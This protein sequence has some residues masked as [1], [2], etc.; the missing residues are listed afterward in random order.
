MHRAF[1]EDAAMT[2]SRGRHVRE[3]VASGAGS[4]R[5]A[6]LVTVDQLISS[7]SN[8]LV[9]IWVAHALPPAGFGRFSLV[10]LI[11]VFTQT[12]VVRSLVSATVVVHP[13]DADERPRWVLGT[14]VLLSVVAGVLCVGAGGILWWA[15]SALGSPVLLVGLLMP[16]LAVQDVGRYLGIAQSRPGKAVVLD[17]IW[18]VL[19]AVGIVAVEVVHKPTLLWIVTA[20]ATT[21]AVAGLW[22]FVQHGFPR[23]RELS[24]DWLRHRWHFSW[25]SLVA[26]SSTAIVAL[27]GSSLMAV[28]SGPVAVAALRAALLLERP[29]TTVQT[30]VATSAATDIARERPDNA[31]LLAYQRRTMILSVA[32]AALNMLVVLMIPDSVGR[33]V[34]GQVWHVV[35]PLLLVVGFHVGAFAAQSGVRAALIGR[36]RIESV[37]MVDI[38]GTVLSIV[39]VV[40]GAA[41]ADAEGAMWG[42]VIGQSAT[43]AVWWMVLL[44]HLSTTAEPAARP[45]LSD[46]TS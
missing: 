8:L 10:F 43:A 28:V 19:M 16:L 23:A 22:V 37:M 1:W 41:M 5:R 26:S 4:G 11:Y 38:V 18:L 3:R 14:A 42:A 24:L 25:R 12:G 39:G 40:V 17:S 21:G 33:L 36:R 15:G 45:V 34:L 20:W 46:A 2:Q 27:V 13:E 9:L 44:R 6:G 30:A 35:Q 29:S 7:A 32:V 31:G